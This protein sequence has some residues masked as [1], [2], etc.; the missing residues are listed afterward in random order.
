MSS[1]DGDAGAQSGGPA[2]PAVEA[3][4]EWLVGALSAEDFLAST[5][6]DR[7]ADDDAVGADE[8]SD[9]ADDGAADDAPEG[10]PAGDDPA[11]DDPAGD[12]PAGDD[13]AGDDSAD[14][15][16]RGDDPPGGD[17][18]DAD[19]PGD[20]PAG[21]DPAG[22]DPDAPAGVDVDDREEGSSDAGPPAPAV[23][24]DR[25]PDSH[26]L[27]PVAWHGAEELR[28]EEIVRTRSRR[29]RR[30]AEDRDEQIRRIRRPLHGAHH[31][32]VTSIRGGVGKTT[33]AACL[34]LV[35]AEHR[36]DRVIALDAHPKAGTLADRLTGVSTQSVRDLVAGADGVRSLADV[37][38]YTSLVRRLQVLASEQDP[39]PSDALGRAEHQRVSGLLAR[40]YDIVVTDT[41]PGL[42]HPSTVATLA[43]ADGLVIAGAPT[44]DGVGHV[45]KTLDWLVVHGHAA[46]VADAVV[47]L[48]RDRSKPLDGEEVRRRF[49]GRVRAVVEVPFDPHLVTGARIE[50]D[51]LRP[52]TR[53]AFVGL[54]AHLADRFRPP[55]APAGTIPVLGVR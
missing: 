2:T 51:R 41:G 1:R 26:V 54:A 55:A 52:A 10:D 14:D 42:V 43:R 21:D 45:G 28:E 11:G 13:P 53:S 38:R 37:S 27:P 49:A 19:S 9:A 5:P 8:A 31:I 18:A 46:R 30:P 12:D 34:G 39:A 24:P 25:G 36:G 40:Y 29:R 20:D 4:D 15:D 33:V 44:A 7:P 6:A 32:A 23:A 47:V 17:Q 22:D 16:A 50:L 48:S 3:G 35:L